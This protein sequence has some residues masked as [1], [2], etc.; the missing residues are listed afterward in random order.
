[1]I[2]LFG[3]LYLYER[4]KIVLVDEPELS[5]SIGWQQQILVDFINAPS[6]RQVIAITHSPFVFDN[7]LEPFARSMKSE[8]DL[9]AIEPGDLDS[10]MD[11][12]A[13][14]GIDPESDL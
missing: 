2:S 5:L 1:M 6:C 3:R 4:E 9:S 11:I 10:D 7:D 12:D 14:L 13:E 8:I